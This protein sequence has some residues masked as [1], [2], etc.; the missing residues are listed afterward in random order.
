MTPVPYMSIDRPVTP[1]QSGFYSLLYVESV[2][3]IFPSENR[4]EIQGPAYFLRPQN[5]RLNPNITNLIA[6]K[7]N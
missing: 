5:A 6:K 7:M 1:D 2:L 4:D 3:P